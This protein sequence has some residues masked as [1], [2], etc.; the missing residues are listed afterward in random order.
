MFGAEQLEWLKNALLFS[1]APIKL[2]V[3]GSQMWNRVNRFEGWN[4][5]A[6]EQKAFAEWLQ[7]EQD[8]WPRV[9]VRRSPLHRSC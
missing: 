6:T 2:V 5:F 7:R 9:S 8:R 3:N 4:Q 1:R